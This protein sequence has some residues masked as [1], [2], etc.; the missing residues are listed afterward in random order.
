MAKTQEDRKHKHLLSF[1]VYMD[2]Q[3]KFFFQ[4]N[5]EARNTLVTFLI[6]ATG[7]VDLAGIYDCFPLLPILNFLYYQPAPQQV[8]GG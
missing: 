8:L 7:H 1:C 2:I 3:F 4:Q 6:S 5:A